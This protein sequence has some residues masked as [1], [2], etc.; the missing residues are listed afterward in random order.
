MIHHLCHVSIWLTQ[1]EI[2][3]F[4]PLIRF[5]APTLSKYVLRFFVSVIYLFGFPDT[6]DNNFKTRAHGITSF[7][8]NETHFLPHIPCGICMTDAFRNDI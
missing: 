3:F 5:L 1:F 4:F 2:E 6:A 8:H 7:G